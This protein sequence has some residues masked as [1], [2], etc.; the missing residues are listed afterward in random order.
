MT[1]QVFRQRP[2]FVDLVGMRSCAQWSRDL[3]GLWSMGLV[4]LRDGGQVEI[5]LA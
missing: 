3:V 5:V 2:V 4:G 1:P